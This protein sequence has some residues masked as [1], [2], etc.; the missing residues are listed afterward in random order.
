MTNKNLAFAGAALL[1]VGLFTPILSMPIVGSVNLF[2]NGSNW[3]ALILLGLAALTAGL[4]AKDRTEEVL[5]PGA[6]VAAILIYLFAR[7]QYALSAMRES[8][9]REL[10]GNP[11]A[12][13]AQTALGSIQL[14]WGWI[15]LAMGAALLV[16]AGINSR[17]GRDA[18]TLE[19][20]DGIAKV[21]AAIAGIAV[22]AVVA[23]DL[24]KGSPTTTTSN[25]S[26]PD[27]AAGP[28]TQGVEAADSADGP[29][30]EEAAYI[31]NNLRLYD[32]DAKYYDSLLEGRVPGVRFKIKNNG[33]RT[34]NE[35]EVRVVFYDEA[36]NAIAEED[37]HPVLVSEYSYSGD[38]KP[39]RPNY[40][41]QQESG[42]FYM[43]KNVPSEW[44]AG[45]ATATITDVEFGPN[46]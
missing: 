4:A 27:E 13:L 32:L 29:T 28:L 9:L 2:N 41:W 10:E 23:L 44:A 19:V 38:N 20:R 24:L 30:A 8:A 7:L 5:W 3:S 16:Y 45:K 17:S 36:G 11:F 18:P 22:V 39:L 46:E 35:V 15:I 31:R 14:Q 34:L 33:N 43:A 25:E 42:K 26:M 6:A 21:A 37:Y 1:V 12:G 40:I